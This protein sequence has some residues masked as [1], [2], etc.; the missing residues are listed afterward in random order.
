M[1]VDRPRI[2]SEPIPDLLL[3]GGFKQMSNEVTAADGSSDDNEAI[4][5]QAVH[6]LGVVV[7]AVLLADT[8][9]GCAAS[10]DRRG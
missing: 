10:V 6:E 4:G 1:S 2:L 5:D 9:D 7:P 8:E 3:V